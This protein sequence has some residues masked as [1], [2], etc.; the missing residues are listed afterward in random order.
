MC[1]DIGALFSVSETEGFDRLFRFLCILKNSTLRFFFFLFGSFLL[2]F[3]ELG[4][5]FFVCENAKCEKGAT[6]KKKQRESE[7][8]FYFD[9]IFC[10]TLLF[11]EIITFAMA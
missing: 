11:I 6:G 1:L 9:E 8:K 5:G 10:T 2:F 4:S 3:H 7:L